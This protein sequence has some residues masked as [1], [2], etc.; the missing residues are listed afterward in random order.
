MALPTSSKYQEF[1]GAASSFATTSWTPNA[2]ARLY[3]AYVLNFLISG[4][5]G[6]PTLSGNGLTWVQDKTKVVD[7]NQRR[8]TTF[9]AYGTGSAGAL[10]ADFAGVSQG[11]AI[12]GVLEQSGPTSTAFVLQSLEGNS[13]NTT[14]LT[15]T[16]DA[17][18]SAS[19]ITIGIF[20]AKGQATTRTVGSGF[21]EIVNDNIDNTRA[22]LVEALDGAD[23]TVDFTVSGDPDGIYTG[24]HLW[25]V[26]FEIAAT[27]GWTVDAT[28][29]LTVDPTELAAY[30][31]PDPEDPVIPDPPAAPSDIPTD[32]GVTS[33][34]RYQAS[35]DVDLGVI[36]R[37]LEGQVR[38]MQETAGALFG[39]LPLLTEDPAS[40]RDG[41]A[42]IRSDSGQLC[43]QVGGETRRFGGTE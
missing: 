12:I 9:L 15:I 27:L 3:I 22:V 28:N 42:W 1:T 11:S 4:S 20:G 14:S 43:W 18:S 21:T 23:T 36:V 24:Q 8:L 26:A 40:P 25:G 38:R 34:A 13:F 2:S 31:A 41:Q 5:A 10:T 19:N 7:S 37:D 39:A 35:R 6:L 32:D 17:F 30:L 33:T 16:L 29:N